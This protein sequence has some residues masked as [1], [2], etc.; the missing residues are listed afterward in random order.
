[1]TST[2]HASDQ[3]IPALSGLV[4]LTSSDWF[5]ENVTQKEKN[6]SFALFLIPN[7]KFIN[8]KLI[9]HFTAC[10][11]FTELMYSSGFE[12]SI[13]SITSQLT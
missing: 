13:F 2:N 9:P 3:T 1:M 7:L 11:L 5:H 6:H 12:L 8:L 10:F 4:G